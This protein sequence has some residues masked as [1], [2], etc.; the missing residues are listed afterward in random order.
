MSTFAKGFSFFYNRIHGYFQNYSYFLNFLEVSICVLAACYINTLYWPVV[1]LGYVFIN[2]LFLD[3]RL[4]T[5]E[6]FKHQLCFKLPHN[7]TGLL[8]RTD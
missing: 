1:N 5:C 7:L 2:V 3:N 6:M 4:I 8:H